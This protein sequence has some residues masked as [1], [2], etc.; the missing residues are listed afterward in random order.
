MDTAPKKGGKKVLLLVE[1]YII[2]GHFIEWEYYKWE[3]TDE[4]T[5][6]KKPVHKQA[7]RFGSSQNLF[8]QPDGWIT[9][10]E[11][12]KNRD[13]LEVEDIEQLTRV[14]PSYLAEYVY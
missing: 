6:I 9:I 4:N 5:K 11:L 14:V 7:W 13:A 3:K 12:L 8:R 1:G 10:K 2:Y